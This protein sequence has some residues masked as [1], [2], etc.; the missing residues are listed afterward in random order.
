MAAPMAL[1]GEHDGAKQTKDVQGK[2][3]ISPDNGMKGRAFNSKRRA[4]AD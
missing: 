3:V 4:G 2:E 1:Q